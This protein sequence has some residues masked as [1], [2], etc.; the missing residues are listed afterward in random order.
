VWD[1]TKVARIAISCLRGQA[2]KWIER[3]DHKDADGTNEIFQQPDISKTSITVRNKKD[4]L[5]GKGP[6]S[7]KL[8]R[9]GC[10]S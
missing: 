5:E 4:T 9:I 7:T 1:D 3:I 6:F 2:L 10:A 8:G